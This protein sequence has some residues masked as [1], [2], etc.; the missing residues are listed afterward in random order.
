MEKHTI[1]YNHTPIM[2]QECIEG[3]NIKPDGIYVD[4]TFGGGGHSGK[5][6]E[7]L[8]TG[9]LIGIDKDDTALAV[10]RERYGN[11][12][13]LTL[14][15]NDFKNIADIL[16]ELGIDQIDGVLLDLGVSSF[17]LDTDYRGFSYRFDAKLDMRMDTT[18]SFSAYDV[19]NSYSESELSNVIFRYGEEPFA[20]KIAREIVEARKVKP[21]ETT[22][23]L[24]KIIEK[25]VFKKKG[26]NPC[27]KTFQAIRI[28][29]NSELDR[30]DTAINTMIDRLRQG[31][32]IAI[33]TFHSLEDRIVKNV[34]KLRSTDCICDKSLPV[35]IC[36]HKK[37]INI[38][39]RKPIVASAEE[40]KINTRSTCAKLR[41]AEKL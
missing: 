2:V 9:R 22:G 40:Q 7:H 41:I 35:C 12:N 14:V 8:T 16:D 15:K 4:G 37:E 31:G 17:Q 25:V 3:L 32:R 28:E 10:G 20:K 1:N 26:S 38:L 13:N 19:V 5:I 36:G 21:I 18:S 34:F 24:V 29:V 30:L 39:T 23:E 33:I 6:L 11:C 27:T